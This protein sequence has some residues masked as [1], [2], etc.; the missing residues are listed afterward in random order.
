MAFNVVVG[1]DTLPKLKISFRGLCTFFDRGAI[2]E[3]NDEK[4]FVLPPPGLTVNF[5]CTRS[6]HDVRWAAQAL[7]KLQFHKEDYPCY[8][9]I[10]MLSYYAYLVTRTIQT[11]IFRIKY[12]PP[13]IGIKYN[14]GQS[15]DIGPTAS[16]YSRNK[17]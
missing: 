6:T 9:K 12:I 5:E 7:V 2:T 3:R 11:H 17:R 4:R 15:V 10:F 16:V 8:T 14:K 1:L 13:F